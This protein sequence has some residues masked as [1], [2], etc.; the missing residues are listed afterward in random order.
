LNILI[1]AQAQFALKTRS[2]TDQF[3]APSTELE[4]VSMRILEKQPAN[5]PALI[6]LSVCQLVTCVC[7]LA[8]CAHGSGHL[9]SVKEPAGAL[10]DGGNGMKPLEI[11]EPVELR[12]KSKQGRIEKVAYLHNSFA[13]S[14]EDAE[15]KNQ[16]DESLEFTSQTETVSDA[17]GK[18]TQVVQVIHK[19]GTADLHDFA[20]PEM[21]E[22]LEI[23]TSVQG[24]ILKAGDYPTNS[25]YYVS[26]VSLPEG[27]VSLGDTWTM[28][29]N[30]LSLDEMVPF[31]LDMVSIL[32]GFW[33]CGKD[34]CAEIE[35]QGDVSLQGKLVKSMTFKS[36][37]RGRIYFDIDAGT[38]VGSR[39]DSDED[40]SAEK[41]HRQIK[42]C[43]A[44]VLLEPAELRLPN[45]TKPAC[46]T[47]LVRKDP[48]T[49][50]LSPSTPP[51]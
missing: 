27:P 20:M 37:W 25:V 30:W 28:Q 49:V 41:V 16:K 50:E 38:V 18:F 8:G 44:A 5:G 7:F 19:D 46:D 13:K 14:Y 23:T 36:T 21:G 47:S 40:M 42:S 2:E 15:I 22:K 10:A 4:G 31:Q 34:R 35:I 33:A 9:N 45:V 24:K 6:L 1:L 48:Q 11:R 43:L 32:K 17:P 3:N 51:K 26:P 12:L 39:V 29:S